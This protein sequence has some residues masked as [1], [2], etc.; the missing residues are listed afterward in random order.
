VIDLG[1][2]EECIDSVFSD[3][4]LLSQFVADY[5]LRHEQREMAQKVLEAYRSDRIFLVEAGTGIGKSWAYLIPALLW[6]ASHRESTIIS[7]H[8][9]ALQEQLIK[10]D[11]PFLLKVLDLELEVILVKGMNNY[12]CLRKFEE[13]KQDKLFLF[14]KEQE[15]LDRLESWADSSREGSFSDLTFPLSPGLWEKVSAERFSCSHMQCPHFKKCFFFKARK[16]LSDAKILIVNHHLLVSEMAARM[17]KDFRE[18]KSILPKTSRLIIDEAHHLEEIALESFSKKTDRLDLIRWLGRLHS[19]H[20]PEKSR[21]QIFLKELASLNLQTRS[22]PILLGTDLPAEKRLVSSH[23]EDLFKKIEFFCS[24]YV[25][26][27]NQ[28]DWK[29]KKWRLKTECLEHPYW[30]EEI[31]PLFQLIAGQ[32]LKISAFI[33]SIHNETSSWDKPVQEH[34]SSHL[35]E[36]DFVAQKLMQKADDLHEFI[37]CE[38]DSR[39]VKWVEMGGS[40][41]NITLVD[42]HLNVSEYLREYLFEPRSTTVL[43]SSTLTSSNSFDSLKDRIGLSR[44]SYQEVEE[45]IYPSPFDYAARTVLAVPKDIPFPNDPR[46]LPLAADLI[47]KMIEVSKGSCFVLFTSY[48]MLNQAYH[49]LSGKIK[50]YT[51]LKQGEASRQTLIDRFKS[52]EGNVLF[53]T[54]SFWEGVDVP[55]EALRCV[56][57]VKLPFKVPSDPLYQAYSELYLQ[58]GKDPFMDYSLPLAALKFK[59]GF[60]RLMRKKLDRGCVLCLDKRLIHKGYGAHFLN[61]IPL[62][63]RIFEDST[64]IFSLL[65]EFYHQT[66]MS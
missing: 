19:E 20:H 2:G 61:S 52:S 47:H 49:L 40:M 42:A 7:T 11:I 66:S 14:P 63:K 35:Q 45:T 1:Y 16:E 38:Q 17:R 50:A 24:T 57:L 30:Q 58:E 26:E 13:C 48:E 39:R 10:K 53:A 34:F 36:L 56:I 8:T 37:S 51:L 54:D 18:E 21:C 3:Q 31:K 64:K 41:L 62:S 29:E 46:F 27:A 32:L 4:G 22:L 6:A 44:E 28:S 55:G 9:I 12:F 43:C 5:E 59:Q 25:K 65:E 15:D 60:G 23:I 33:E